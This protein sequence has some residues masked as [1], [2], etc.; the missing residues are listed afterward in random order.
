[1][2]IQVKKN[3]LRFHYKREKLVKSRGAFFFTGKA[4]SGLFDAARDTKESKALNQFNS[5]FS[6][7]FF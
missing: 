2:I 6:K 7:S 3:N 4:L 5:S 1:M